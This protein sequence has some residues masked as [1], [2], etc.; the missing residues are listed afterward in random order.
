MAVLGLMRE[1]TPDVTAVDL[2]DHVIR[3]FNVGVFTAE[4]PVLTM[5]L[6]SGELLEAESD[7]LIAL[8]TAWQEDVA[9]LQ[10]D[11]QHLE[12]TRDEVITGR[13]IELGGCPGNGQQSRG[14]RRDWAGSVHGRI[15]GFK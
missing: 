11:S 15:A 10:M 7:S 12:R 6:Q 3:S 4:H 14:L 8:V 1:P 9:H 13:A 5:M 2:R